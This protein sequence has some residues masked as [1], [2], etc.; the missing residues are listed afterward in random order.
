MSAFRRH[1]LLATLA[2]AG[3]AAV[4]FVWL[5]AGYVPLRERTIARFDWWAHTPAQA[6]ELARASEPESSWP[7]FGGSPARTRY[8]PSELRPPFRRVFTIRGRSLIEMPPIVSEGRVVFGTHAGVVIAASVHDG[9][10]L[11]TARLGRCIAASPTVANGVVYVGWSGRAPCTRGKDELG[12]VVALRLTTGE[13]LWQFSPGNVESSPMVVDGTLFFSSYR[14]RSDSRVFAIRL[15]PRR[16]VRWSYPIATKI[17]SAPALIGRTLFVSAYDRSL[18][19]FDARTGRLRW[20][21][22]AFSADTGERLLLGVRSLVRRRSWDEG[23]FY[24]TPAI[25]YR[26][27]YLGTIDGVFSAFDARTGT[28]RWSR[29][30]GGAIYGS[31]AIW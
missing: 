5:A 16:A 27:A 30:L 15:T 22:T 25:A 14:S 8:V 11:W 19:S 7:T 31:A 3:V 1:P 23:G 21:T 29:R 13:V 20:R 10:R 24:A 17:A 6:H 9:S 12:G 26:R 18:Y 2:A 28:H 4:G